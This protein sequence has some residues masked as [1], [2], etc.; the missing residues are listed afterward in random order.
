MV[1][2]AWLLLKFP[3][4]PASLRQIILPQH[5]RGNGTKWTTGLNAFASKCCL[6]NFF[7]S[8]NINKQGSAWVDE[9]KDNSHIVID[10]EA[11]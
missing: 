1:P 9:G 2:T 11:P 10:A 8:A 7:M 4:V 5:P 3:L 6:I